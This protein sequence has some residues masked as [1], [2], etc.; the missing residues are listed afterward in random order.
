MSEKQRTGGIMFAIDSPELF[1][2]LDAYRRSLGWTW[3]RLMLMGVAEIIAQNK[4]NPHLAMDLVEYI[5]ARR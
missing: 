3:R 4:D 2:A 5:N 1:D